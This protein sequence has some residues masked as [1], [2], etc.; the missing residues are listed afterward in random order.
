VTP[1]DIAGIVT[2]AVALVALG[3]GYVQFVLR[4]SGLGYVEFDVDL[5]NHHRGLTQ[6]IA[7]IACVIK[8]VGSSMVIVTN[9]Q[10]RA[11]Y[12]LAGDSEDSTN[13]VEPTFEHLIVPAT[14]PA[15][16]SLGEHWFFVMEPRTF[17]QPGVTQRYRKPIVMP[18]EAQV[19]HVWGSFDYR[20]KTKGLTR[21]LIGLAAQPPTDMDWREGIR[22]HTVRRTFSLAASYDVRESEGAESDCPRLA[23]RG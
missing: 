12:R 5:T 10:C 18:V 6:L 2:A 13:G 7:E 1:G 14:E 8:N 22:N 21:A 20:I 3:G 19:L 9:V 23:G 11:R 4:R 15:G 17:I 16:T